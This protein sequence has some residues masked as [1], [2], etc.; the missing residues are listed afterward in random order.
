MGPKTVNRESYGKESAQAA[1]SERP[2]R[3]VGPDQPAQVRAHDIPAEVRSII[4]TLRNAGGQGWVVGG[5]IR[6]LLLGRPVRDW[7]VATDLPP[8]KL[9]TLFPR[10]VE[11][12]ARFGTVVV[13]GEH[14]EYEV[15]TFRQDQG[16]SDGRHPDAVRYSTN[17]ED[18]LAR[19][20]FTVNAIAFEP[21]SETLLDPFGGL[22]DLKARLL[23]TVGR[24][25]ERFREDGLRLLR[26]VR[27]ASQ[28]DFD[29]DPATLGSLV[30]N[31]DRLDAI[32]AERVAA[33]LDRIL[34]QDGA[35][36]AL[37][38]LLETGLLRKI[39]PELSHCYGV[40]QNTFHAFSVFYHLLAAVDAA[41]SSD[42][43]VR[44]AA[45]FHDVGKPETREET[46][47]GTRSDTG[48]GARTATETGTGSGTKT[49]TGRKVT[50][51]SHQVVSERQVRAAFDRL[52]LSNLDKETVA[53]L[54]E[55]HMFHYTPD[56][57]DGAVRRFLRTIGEEHI[58][59]LYRLRRADTLGNG[60]RTRVAPELAILRGRIDQVLAEDAALHVRDLKIGGHDLMKE[61]GRGPGP[62]IGETLQHLLGIVLDEPAENERD[63]LL[64]HARV[65]LANEQSEGTSS[66]S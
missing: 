66:S 21:E 51:Y 50:F 18:D 19:R 37:E 61:F 34:T 2:V 45:L 57:T 5:G 9:T 10:T 54:V 63:R 1:R 35:A 44:W 65:F 32:S 41:E 55:H 20:D 26:A 36:R 33:E 48:T 30:R 29:I 53:H 52:R 14:G 58:D 7:D 6:D 11:V 49:K 13:I 12:G 62:W 56:W 15:T 23:R 47:S 31:A 64:E 46:E 22:S 38:L 17:P 24:P 28:L 4:G 40:S 60:V 8:Q 42:R 16:Y 59:A 25:D 3:P 27:L 39:L 43:I